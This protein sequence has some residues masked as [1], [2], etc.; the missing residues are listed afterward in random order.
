M[1]KLSAES[2]ITA[3]TIGALSAW[4]V[5]VPVAALIWF[6]GGLAGSNGQQVGLALFG[7]YFVLAWGLYLMGPSS[8]VLGAIGGVIALKLA[9]W[10]LERSDFIAGVAGCGALLGALNGAWPNYLGAGDERLLI[11][12][13][14]IAGALT[15]P[16]AGLII[17]RVC[18]TKAHCE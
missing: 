8:L 13:G 4:L 6:L 18:K 12:L 2:V 9:Q 10:R 17:Q 7:A 11:V 14:A 15:G 1:K 3:A 16:I 5:G